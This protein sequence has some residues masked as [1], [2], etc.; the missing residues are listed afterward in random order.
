MT[1]MTSVPGAAPTGAYLTDVGTGGCSAWTLPS[2]ERCPGAA[3]VIARQVLAAAGLPDGYV[4]DAALC[5]SEL[6]TNAIMHPPAE[7]FSAER[8]GGRLT[9]PELWLYRRGDA[10]NAQLVFVV[11]DSLRRWRDREP[12]A[13]DDLLAEDGR[14]LGIVQ[15]MAGGHSGWHPSRS[16]LGWSVAGKACWFAL[17]IP[18]A[19]T[20]AFPRQRFATV[21]QGA[22]MLARLLVDRGLRPP[23]HRDAE[24]QSVLS[25]R[26][27]LTVWCRAGAF[28]WTTGGTTHQR[29]LSDVID[30]AERIV[31]LHEEMAAADPGEGG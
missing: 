18:P 11:F 24:R 19:S 25:V 16:R 17:P 2:D 1:A 15:A 28:Q 20:A 30:V 6:A 21:A 10:G 26:H 22:A 4:A 3:R 29:P 23:I 12:A 7:R 8:A 9:P 13:G 27:G 14:G 5:V 31:Q